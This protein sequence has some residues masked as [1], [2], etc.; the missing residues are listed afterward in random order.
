VKE[1]QAQLG[2][3]LLRR[4]QFEEVRKRLS[5][6]WLAAQERI[7]GMRQERS[8]HR[9]EWRERMEGHLARWRETIEH[10]RSQRE[11]L[12]LQ[13]AKL[14]D[15]EKN[16]RSEEFAVQVRGWRDETTEKLRRTEALIAELEERVRDAA[17]KVSGR[18]GGRRPGESHGGTG[19]L[20]AP[21]E[22]GG[23]AG[24]APPEAGGSGTAGGEPP[25]A[26]GSGASADAPTD[27]GSV[28]D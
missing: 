5:E 9:A 6:A 11:H 13:V 22:H 27:E 14:E 17:R 8:R 16:A 4:G 21:G 19:E 2:R 20:T 3:A 25:E 10:K 18:G 15:M 23:T 28:G 24:D 7:A 12:V 1:L 26:G